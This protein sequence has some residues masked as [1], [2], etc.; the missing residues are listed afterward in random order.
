MSVMARHNQVKVCAIF[1][2]A[3]LIVAYA[4]ERKPQT[5]SS[6][7]KATVYLRGVP[8]SASITINDDPFRLSNTEQIV[9]PPG[10]IQLKVSYGTT[11]MVKS[12]SVGAG[13]VKVINFNVNP[14]FSVVDV[15]TDPLGAEVSIDEKKA[16]ETPLL[17]ST[18]EPGPHA[19]VIK[20][21]A[22][23][24]IVKEVNLIPQEELELTFELKKSK[25]W[26]DSVNKIK[27]VKRQKRRFIQ[28]VVY[29]ALGAAS[30]G[31]ALYFDQAA[32]KNIRDAGAF[33]QTYDLAE[34]GCDDL[35][36]Q[37]YDNRAAAKENIERRD[38]VAAVSGA[39]AL[40]FA[41]T[42]IF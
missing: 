8:N 17:D 39:I 30:A 35:R 6:G 40:G 15:I 11:Q 27:T 34:S 42:F 10:K 4:G 36:T 22:Y 33:A 41:L 28:R 2:L 16:G 32:N 13:E 14:D 38:I 26:A 3:A 20:K 7:G 12:F 23:E 18:V 31:A 9:F 5:P 25:V 37:Y 1:V 29:T 24:T 21:Y 19:I